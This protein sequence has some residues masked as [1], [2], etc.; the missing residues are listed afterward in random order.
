MG[1]WLAGQPVEDVPYKYQAG[2]GC[3]VASSNQGFLKKEAFIQF[4]SGKHQRVEIR[5]RL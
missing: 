4:D 5:K 3:R 2:K 1:S